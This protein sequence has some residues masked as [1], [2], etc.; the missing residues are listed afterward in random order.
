M[1]KVLMISYNYPPIGDVGMVRTLKFS[2]YLPQHGWIPHVLTVKNRDRFYKSTSNNPIPG[3]VHVHRSIN[4]CN[5]LSLARGAL[6]AAGI[7]SE[8][9]VPDVYIGWIPLSVRKGKKIIKTHD[10]DL[11]YASCPPHSSALIAAKLKKVTGLPFV[12][13][14]RDAWTLNPYAAPEALG[15]IQK[16]NETMER[17]AM[18]SADCII[19]AFDAIKR[20][21]LK[22]Y[23]FLKNMYTLTNGFDP[24]DINVSDEK[25]DKFTIVYTGYFFGSRSP[26]PL[27]AALKD[28]LNKGLIPESDIQFLWAGSPAPFVHQL[29]N[30]YQIN[31]IVN[32]MGLL[33]KKEADKLLY[34]SHLLLYVSGTPLKN[35]GPGDSTNLCGKLFPYL[36][37]GTPLLGILP[38]G[39]AREMIEKY[40][41]DSYVVE[42]GEVDKIR[43]AILHAYAK[44]RNGESETGDDARADQFRAEFNYAALTGKLSDIFDHVIKANN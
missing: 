34:K 42:N 27:F 26:E 31:S 19:A 21:Y 13:D 4:I 1:K 12:L 17:K 8:L 24:E 5:N 41:P 18:Q 30:I 32:Y 23:S 11:I 10:I 14:L 29:V 38:G 39:D 43:D 44:W 7:R 28:I 20:D 22:K 35:I 25:F 2:K 40:S 37:S 3:G 9:I 36:A 6:R 15:V 33:P 16:K